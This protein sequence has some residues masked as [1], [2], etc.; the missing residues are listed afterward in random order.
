MEDEVEVIIDVDVIPFNDSPHGD[1]ERK[2]KPESWRHSY[3]TPPVLWNET[4]VSR[5]KQGHNRIEDRRWCKLS[6]FGFQCETTFSSDECGEVIVGFVRRDQPSTPLESI[7]AVTEV[8]L[9]SSLLTQWTRAPR[10]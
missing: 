4:R 1:I 10:S 8:H 6:S 7:D 3:S 2:I 5:E 9:L